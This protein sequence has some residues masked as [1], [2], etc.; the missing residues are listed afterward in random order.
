MVK[1]GHDSTIR[2]KVQTFEFDNGKVFLDAWAADGKANLSRRF[3]GWSRVAHVF[4]VTGMTAV[5]FF[6]DWGPNEHI[7]SD[8][9]RMVGQWWTKFVELDVHDVAK[10]RSVDGPV[11]T[12]ATYVSSA[13]GEKKA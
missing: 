2:P 6:S 7:F 1:E 9:R 8:A 11:S 13:R 10:A 5:L 12:I 4:A 3:I